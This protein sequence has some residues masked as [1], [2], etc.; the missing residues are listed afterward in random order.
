M[1]RA[2]KRAVCAAVL[3]SSD[4]AALA[5]ALAVAVGIRVSV[6]PGL[7]S[8][9]ARPTYPL[10]HYLL[11]WWI[12]FAYL[13]SLAHAGLY[14]RR[15]PYW[16][17][18][19]RCL[20]GASASALLI[21]AVLS[22]ARTND[23]VS[24]PVV[25]LAWA[26]LLMLLPA[27]RLATKEALYALGPWRKTT[28]LLGAGPLA[29]MLCRAFRRQ[30]TLGYDVVEVVANPARAVERAVALGA[31]EIIV[32]APELGRGEFLTLVEQLRGA[33]ENVLIAPDLAEAPVFGVEAVGL[34]DD[35]AILLR[36]PCNLLKPWNVALKRACDLVLGALLGALALPLVAA[37]AAAIRL[38]SP[39]PVFHIE[40]RVGRK[41]RTFPCLKLRTMHLDAQERLATHLA[42]DPEAAREWTCYRKLRAYDPRVTRVGRLLRRYAIDE[43]PQLWN[44]LRGD[45]SLVGPRPY[46]LREMPFVEGDGMLD[47]RP[48]LTGLWQ[49]SGKNQVT[50]HER[51]RIDRWYVNNWSSWL[52]LII[53]VRTV[54]LLVGGEGGMGNVR[55]DLARG[56]GVEGTGDR[57]VASPVGDQRC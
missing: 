54:P 18:A 43:I 32:A 50:F 5:A 8:A 31:Q 7:S 53:L 2:A 28:L 42:A 34:L 23:D 49:V 56:S 20:V 9:F 17:E 21:F 3:V 4:L 6:L 44:V 36:I 1:S 52:D 47:V 40:P 55:T 10:A 57:S 46:L 25:V 48:G 27:A 26:A 51:T 38:D 16:E 45:M 12:P 14:T 35:R 24:R 13:A 30:R 33:V 29:E 37:A 15:D 19:R 22:A 39:G 41:R 11:L